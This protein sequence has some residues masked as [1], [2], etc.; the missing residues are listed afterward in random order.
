MLYKKT[1]NNKQ[2]QPQTQL[3]SEN[4][5][6]E[7]E[8]ANESK[9][10]KRTRIKGK[11]REWKEKTKVRDWNEQESRGKSVNQ[12]M[13]STGKKTTRKSKKRDTSILSSNRDAQY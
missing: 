2:S 12:A 9:R 6:A 13:K 3:K 11:K 4:E 10:L 8:L 7:K 1:K 5:L